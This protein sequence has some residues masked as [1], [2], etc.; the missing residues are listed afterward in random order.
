[1]RKKER[2][3]SDSASLTS[4]PGPHSPLTLTHLFV[5]PP[6]LPLPPPPSSTT[7]NTVP[8]R[9]RSPARP[10]QRLPHK[11][12]EAYRRTRDT[13]A[14][15]RHCRRRHRRR[16]RMYL[17]GSLTT[18]CCV[19]PRLGMSVAGWWWGRWVVYHG[20]LLR[21]IF[22]FRVFRAGWMAMSWVW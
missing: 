15:S 19:R 11:E 1:M 13:H 3:S 18:K 2:T 10:S 5:T 9:P 6:P 20:R 14:S 16:W 12:L 21:F 17:V 4:V 7:P 8:S 22:F